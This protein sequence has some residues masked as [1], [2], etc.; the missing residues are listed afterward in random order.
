MLCSA[1]ERLRKI[2]CDK[3]TDEQ[4][5]YLCPLKFSKVGDIKIFKN[6]VWCVRWLMLYGLNSSCF[7]A[8]TPPSLSL[9]LPSSSLLCVGDPG[10]RSFL[11]IPLSSDW[12]VLTMTAFSCNSQKWNVK[13][14]I[15]FRF[16]IRETKQNDQWVI[17]IPGRPHNI[18]YQ[19]SPVRPWPCIYVGTTCRNWQNVKSNTGLEN[20]S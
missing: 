8:P 3:W 9:H 13:H 1:R 12:G 20:M 10:D 14:E 4:S 5:K 19:S 18:Q 11:F 15:E 16:D 6:V 2:T 17:Y 7:K